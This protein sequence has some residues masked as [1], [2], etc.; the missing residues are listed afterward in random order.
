MRRRNEAPIRWAPKVRRE[1]IRRVYEN[2][3]RGICD[4]ELIDEVGYA[5]YMRCQSILDVT[6]AVRGRVKCHGCGR[7]IQ[8]TREE[9]LQCPECGWEVGWKDYQRSYQEKQLFGGA[10]LPFFQA[11]V[12]Q[13]FNVRTPREKLLLIDRLIHEFHWYQKA[14][15]ALPE[16]VRP[17]AANLIEGKGIREVLDFLDSLTNGESNSVI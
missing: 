2:D 6:E 3:A 11:Y 1:Q 17:A 16:P 5:L 4:E 9:H 10:A 8:H 7:V 13:F 15:Q 14:N 12:E